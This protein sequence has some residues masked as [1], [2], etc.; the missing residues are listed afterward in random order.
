[1]KKI[2][3]LF[4]ALVLTLALF[5]G[6]AAE[7][8]DFHW[9]ARDV[10]EDCKTTF[11]NS[12][13]DE[14]G[15]ATYG[16]P[17]NLADGGYTLGVSISMTS[18]YFQTVAASFTE[19]AERDG[20]EVITVSAE[21]D[22]AKQIADIEDL[23]AAGCKA[24]CISAFDRA[25]ITPALLKIQEAGVYCIAF[26]AAPAETKYCQGFVGTDNYAAG[27]EGGL[28]MMKDYPDGG[29]VAVLSA[30]SGSAGV[31][32][33][34]GFLAAIE[35]SNLEVAVTLDAD[36][37]QTL[38]L[39]CTN[40]ILEAHDDIVAIWGINDQCIMGAYAACTTVGRDVGLYGV[41]G[42]PEA[43]GYIYENGIYKMT[44]G[45]SPI[46]IGAAM[47]SLTDAIVAQADIDYNFTDVS[48]IV[49]T[50]ETVEPYLGDQWT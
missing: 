16:D 50:P 45:Q 29:K 24:I 1:M 35:G 17:I 25:A 5:V 47:Y 41:D 34:D 13:H 40:D 26:D 23:I 31:F 7:N 43:K 37:D 27:Y 10:S 9:E 18:D 33:E 6:A 3:T 28:R 44:A 11:V 19:M 15:V 36:G 14:Y 22:A 39:N 38:G 20:N 12:W 8:A 32:R 42:T 4:L 48:V 49:M 2:T 21:R 46:T 30:P